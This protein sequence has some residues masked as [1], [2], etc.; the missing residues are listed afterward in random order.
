MRSLDAHLELP[1]PLALKSFTVVN[2]SEIHGIRLVF[3]KFSIV[4]FA[5]SPLWVAF[6]GR[7]G[8]GVAA[9]E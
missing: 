3:R 4:K 2:R 8:F 1:D 6:G 5:T 7:R 9:Q